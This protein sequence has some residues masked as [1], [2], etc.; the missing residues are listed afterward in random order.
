MA[1]FCIAIPKWKEDRKEGME[2]GK[3]GKKKKTSDFSLHVYL[4]F[5][6]VSTL[7]ELNDHPRMVF[8]FFDH[9]P[10][11]HILTSLNFWSIA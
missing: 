4:V 2:G 10:T 3:R 1:I 5:L 7:W 6:C 8:H 9:Y 11:A